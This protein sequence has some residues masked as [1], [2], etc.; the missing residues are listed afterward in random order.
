MIALIK[1][2][3]KVGIPLTTDE[4]MKNKKRVSY[5][6]VLVEVDIS[7]PLTRTVPIYFSWGKVRQQPVKY[8]FELKF[9]S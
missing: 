7:K 4:M 5:A 1:I 2:T 3:S 8:E 9:C 6:L